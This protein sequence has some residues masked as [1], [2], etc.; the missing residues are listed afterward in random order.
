VGV[1]YSQMLTAIGGT[2]A[3]T[4]RVSLGRLPAWATLDPSTG[5]ISGTP[6]SESSGSLLGF[7]VTDS[8]SPQQ[9]ATA[10]FTLVVLTTP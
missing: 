5:V 10:A 7:Q 9:T 1:F 2:G 3:R 6:T 8:G 4:W